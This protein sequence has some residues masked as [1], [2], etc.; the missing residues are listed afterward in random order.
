METRIFKTE[1]R[2]FCRLPHQHPGWLCHQDPKPEIWTELRVLPGAAATLRMW[3]AP[4]L[5]S[6]IKHNVP[7]LIGMIA[8]KL[9]NQLRKAA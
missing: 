2:A 9:F 7:C 5:V 6:I 1:K 3:A 8:F 4:M